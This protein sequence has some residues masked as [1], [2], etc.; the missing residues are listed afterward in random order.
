MDRICRF[1]Y[2]NAGLPA[3][4]V[5]RWLTYSGGDELAAYVRQGRCFGDLSDRMLRAAWKVALRDYARHPTDI[6]HLLLIDLLHEFELRNLPG[7][8]ALDPK[9]WKI[10]MAQLEKVLEKKLARNPDC[11][12]NAVREWIEKE[13]SSVN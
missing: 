6:H 10:A 11:I 12:R 1:Y 3:D 4:Q 9:N 8:S 13:P 2:E 5:S 7:P